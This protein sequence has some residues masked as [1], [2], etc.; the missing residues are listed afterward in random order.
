MLM[1][2]L[3]DQVPAKEDQ[4]YIT[5]SADLAKLMRNKARELIYPMVRYKIDPLDFCRE[6]HN[7]K[8]RIAKELYEEIC[9]WLDEVPDYEE[10]AT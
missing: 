5:V 8:D 3:Q 6:A 1:E 9:R 4:V 7:E 2:T 10:E